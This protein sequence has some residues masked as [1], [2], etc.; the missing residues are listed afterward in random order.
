MTEA[1]AHSRFGFSSFARRAACPASALREDGL[2]DTVSAAAELGTLLHDLAAGVLTGDLMMDAVR[3]RVGDRHASIV[4]EYVL[5]VRER[6][7]ELGGALHIE[8]RFHIPLHEELW[9]T[10]DA[11][12]AAPPY[13][14][15]L[16]LKTGGG[17]EV[18]ERDDEGRINPQLA[19]YLLGALHAVPGVYDRF[20]ITVVQ[21]R[22]G[23]IKRTEVTSEELLDFAGHVLS[24]VEKALAPNA[25]A[26]PGDHCLFCR[27]KPGCEEYRMRG[28][29]AA[30][31]AFSSVPI[32]AGMAD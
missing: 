9:G 10:A 8:R 27:A 28:Y 30:A 21:P 23:G 1:P 15:V 5:H 20:A 14:E 4:G 12:I 2:A 29:R 17:H 16:D 18:K 26:H 25:I 32:P 3:E 7:L 22:R 24:V 6:H 11:V 31:A 19:G 13:M